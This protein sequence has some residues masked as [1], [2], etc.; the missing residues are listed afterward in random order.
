MR[1]AAGEITRPEDPSSASCDAL[2]VGLGGGVG[3]ECCLLA[4]PTI[5]TPKANHVCTRCTTDQRRRRH[6]LTS[7]RDLH[8]LE[9]S[10]PPRVRKNP[11]G[12]GQ[13]TGSR[14]H[15]RHFG[16]R[17]GRIGSALA[18]RAGRN[19]TQHKLQYYQRVW[20]KPDNRGPRKDL[21]CTPLLTNNG[22]EITPNFGYVG[23]TKENLGVATEK[24]RIILTSA[25]GDAAVRRSGK[26]SCPGGSGDTGFIKSGVASTTRA[27]GVRKAGCRSHDAT[28]IWATWSSA[29]CSGTTRRHGRFRRPTGAV[30]D[31]GSR[32]AATRR[33][34]D[35][36]SDSS[37]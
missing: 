3:A 32:A 1:A 19:R 12:S 28:G 33:K 20:E 25:K 35:P 11:E 36:L 4:H 24:I 8:T 16:L 21:M 27:M 22:V 26:R 23:L 9:A 6:R 31:R 18:L 17:A 2:G 13:A 14:L 5:I 37:I 30:G 10:P 34:I 29:S 7:G 15:R